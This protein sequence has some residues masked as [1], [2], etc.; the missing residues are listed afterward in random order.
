MLPKER[1]KLILDAVVREEVA[2]VETLCRVTGASE[3]TVRRDL[4]DM[5]RR[6]EILRTRGG[7]MACL[8]GTAF[9]P[10]FSDKKNRCTGEKKRIG[11]EAAAM[12]RPG[13]TVLLD[14]GTTTLEIARQ[15]TR[16]KGVT[17]VTND[18]AIAAVLAPHPGV[19]LIVAGGRLRGGVYT[20]LGPFTEDFLG[21]LH[22]DR[23]FL[24]ADA[25]NLTHGVMNANVE[26]VAVKRRMIAAARECVLVCDHTKVGQTALADICPLS[27]IGTMI[28]GR[29]LPEEQ[30]RG[31]GELDIELILV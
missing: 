29:E 15:L 18:I 21:Q 30:A 25:V 3:A 4:T 17:V 16:A 12:I 2:S 8:Q 6:G 26:E 19:D 11:R 9:E 27:R 28:T 5:T 10:A 23:L 20:L 14:A 7:A 22:V 1:Q 31:L 24:G 13:E